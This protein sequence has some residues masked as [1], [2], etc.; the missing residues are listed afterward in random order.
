MDKLEKITDMIFKLDE[1]DNT[2]NLKDGRPGSTLF[3]YYV[4]DSKQFTH[5]EP[6]TPQY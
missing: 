4:S 3:T 5:L 1:L 2:N 6:S